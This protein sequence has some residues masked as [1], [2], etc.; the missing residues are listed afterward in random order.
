MKKSFFNKTILGNFVISEGNK[1]KEIQGKSVL[2]FTKFFLWGFCPGFFWLGRLMSGGVCRGFMS[3][4]FLS[5][6]F[7]PDTF[8]NRRRCYCF[9]ARYTRYKMFQKM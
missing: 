2:S 6:G 8:K 7:C 4:G 5:E 9:V 3:G 1:S